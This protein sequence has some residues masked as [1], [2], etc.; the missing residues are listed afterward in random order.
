MNEKY[1]IIDECSV[2]IQNT[3]Q[4]NNTKTTI[5]KTWFLPKALQD[6]RVIKWQVNNEMGNLSKYWG[7][8][9]NKYLNK[10]TLRC[11]I[12]ILWVKRHIFILYI[13]Q[14]VTKRT[15]KPN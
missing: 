3:L 13:Q 8:N 12:N 9:N 2:K 5:P 10:F 6:N 14:V 1:N 15:I 7:W 11:A 4:V